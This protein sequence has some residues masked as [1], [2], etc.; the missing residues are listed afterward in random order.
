MYFV[1]MVLISEILFSDGPAGPV[2]Y[3]CQSDTA[4]L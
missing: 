1:N 2:L 4:P 3:A